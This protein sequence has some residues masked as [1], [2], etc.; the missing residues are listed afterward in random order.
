MSL[1]VFKGNLLQAVCMLQSIFNCHKIRFY[2]IHVHGVLCR[3]P[4]TCALH[5]PCMFVHFN[6][7]DCKQVSVYLVV[8]V[9]VI[10]SQWVY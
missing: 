10:E 6:G 7:I 5:L 4:N 3:L 2:T 8:I 9:N 1:P